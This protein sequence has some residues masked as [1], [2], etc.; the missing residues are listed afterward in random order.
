MRIQL[1]G[2]ISG[3]DDYKEKFEKAEKYLIERGYH[4]V[5]PVTIC[6]KMLGLSAIFGEMS[7]TDIWNACMTVTTSL[8]IDVD[9][10]AILPG[11]LS[12]GATIEALWAKRL[13]KPFL[14]IPDEV[15][16]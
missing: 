4:V 16:K 6:E 13:K 7:D 8:L 15:V 9:A 1:I 3:H 5:N 14:R 11:K 2:P 10:I 12:P